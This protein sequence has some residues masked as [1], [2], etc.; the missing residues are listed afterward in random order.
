MKEK[1]QRHGTTWADQDLVE[2]K[3]NYH[4]KDNCLKK[5]NFSERD[6]L[7]PPINLKVVNIA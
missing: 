2:T 7:V 1:C 5:T 4:V 6:L 3:V